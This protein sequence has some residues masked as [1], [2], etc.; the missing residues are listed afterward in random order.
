M[1]AMCA[2]G[3]WV[4][5][6]R[7]FIVTQIERK[8]ARGVPSDAARRLCHALAFGGLSTPEAYAVIRDAD[9][10][11]GTAHELLDME[12][13]PTDRTYRDAWR[14]S[15]NG[16]PIYLDQRKVVEIDEHRAW[17]AYERERRTTGTGET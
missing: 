8:I 11:H 3:F 1:A 2:G 7:G 14:R 12:D 17:L 6:P 15:H 5:P 16:G 4:R 13:L 10:W 9:C